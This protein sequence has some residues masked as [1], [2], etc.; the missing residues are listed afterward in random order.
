[1]SWRAG[2]QVLNDLGQVAG[3]GQDGKPAIWYPDGS[4]L[5]LPGTASEVT[6]TGFNNQGTVVGNALIPGYSLPQPVV[7]R[8]GGSV[9]RLPFSGL[10]GYTE[11][12]NNRGDIIGYMAGAS[13][14]GTGEPI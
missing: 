9:E 12:I 1:M 13:N 6:I 5:H 4:I 8:N 11:G 7:W 2:P 10:G 14:T 3:I